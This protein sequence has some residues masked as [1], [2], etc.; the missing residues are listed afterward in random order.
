MKYTIGEVAK[1]TGLSV[2]TLRYY[3]E[4]GLLQHL[5]RNSSGHREFSDLD[6]SMVETILHLKKS[7]LELEEIKLFFEYFEEGEDTLEQRRDMFLGMRE[8]MLT[9][10][11]EVQETIE[12]LNYK[13][14]YYEEAVKH[15]TTAVPRYMKKEDLPEEIRDLKQRLIHRS[16]SDWFFLGKTEDDE[17]ESR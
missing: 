12:M 17:G 4:I 2:P 13:C 6:L 3:D 10:L 5:G 1:K 8:R 14:W 7:G 15:G 11:R 16:V 9:R